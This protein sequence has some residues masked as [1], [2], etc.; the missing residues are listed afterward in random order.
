MLNNNNKSR[1]LLLFS[2]FC[3]VAIFSGKIV[4]AAEED[5]SDD[6]ERSTIT[7]KAADEEI[8]A[9]EAIK[10]V[11]EDY[12][13]PSAPASAYFADFFPEDKLSP[14]WIQ[15]EAKKEGIDESIAKYDGKWTTQLAMD[16]QVLQNLYCLIADS[17]ARHHAISAKFDRFFNFK[18]KKP[19]IV[20]YDVKFQNGLECGGA[21]IKLLSG[22]S[23]NLKEFND[24]T[25]YTIMFGPDK[26]GMQSKLHFIIRFKHPKTGIVT[27][28]H[29]KQPDKSLD[30]YFTDKKSHLYTLEFNPDGSYMIYIDQYEVSRGNMLG[31]LDPPI[32]PQKEIDDPDDKKPTDWDER[33]KI[34]DPEAKKPE[35]WNEDAPE[36]I[37]DKDAKMPSDWLPEESEYV[38]DENAK[39]P[40]D[41][42]EEMDG[43]WEAPLIKN[44]KCEKVSGCGNWT[45]PMIKNPDY[46]GKW[47]APMINNPAYQGKWMPRKIQNPDYFEL[48]SPFEALEPIG[49][50]G[51]E[52]WTMTEGIAFDNFLVVDDKSLADSLA[53]QSWSVKFAAE[54]RSIAKSSVFANLVQTANDKP[55]LWAIYLLVILIPIILIAI[56]CFTGSKKDKAA[57]SKK[58]DASN[59]DDDQFE[60]QQT[61]EFD[62][63]QQQPMEQ[64]A[65]EEETAAFKQQQPLLSDLDAAEFL[66]GEVTPVAANQDHQQQVNS[67]KG[68]SGKKS[69]SP[70]SSKKSDDNKSDRSSTS[71]KKLTKADLEESSEES[72]PENFK[73]EQHND[74][75]FKEGS[76]SPRRRNVRKAD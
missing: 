29:A 64:G 74:N 10:F 20:Q 1:L 46:K 37:V 27:E 67:N 60:S 53:S 48:D 15:S 65:S 41:W 14:K 39:K 56:F 7:T 66:E 76:G 8:I 70:L 19:F 17:K 5:D 9:E 62:D 32:V 72:G 61:D 75:S 36:K 28:H 44:P 47:K 34:P 58:T 11:P 71:P 22:N 2:I 24:K 33:E 49:A 40:D 55:W 51:L 45:P 54:G 31:S 13:A 30:T 73:H 6:D 23:I 68:S 4:R 69:K 25:P 52:L 16:H 38:P 18:S 21:Y 57:Y 26:C 59:P 3:F 63:D 12:T 42:D 43:K 35:D 50:I